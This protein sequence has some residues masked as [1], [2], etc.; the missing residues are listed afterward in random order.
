M[1]EKMVSFDA[2]LFPADERAPH[3][4]PLMT[5][6]SS[7]F[8]TPGPSGSQPPPPPLTKIP[9]PEMYMDFIAEG[10]GSRAWQYHVSFTNSSMFFACF[11]PPPAFQIPALGFSFSSLPVSL[12]P[13]AVWA[14]IPF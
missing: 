4:V 9:H 1:M 3:L 11:H 12:A 6:D 14:A 5:S 7:T 2:I 10:V 8:P 13:E